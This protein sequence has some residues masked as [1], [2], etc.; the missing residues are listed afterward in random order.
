[1]KKS[2]ETLIRHA[3]H[4]SAQLI[5]QSRV[6]F[7]ASRVLPAPAE[8][9]AFNLATPDAQL[10][11]LAPFVADTSQPLYITVLF[12]TPHAHP[13][14]LERWR[15]AYEQ[16]AKK[17][18]SADVS[19]EQLY[20]NAAVLMRVLYGFLC[21]LPCSSIVRALRRNRATDASLAFH[22]EK[23]ESKLL[24]EP[25]RQ[26]V[27]GRIGNSLGAFSITAL[28][29]ADITAEEAQVTGAGAVLRSQLIVTDY[30]PSSSACREV[31]DD[32]K[33][34]SPT[35]LSPL[36]QQLAHY[37]VAPTRRSSS[38]ISIGSP[39]ASPRSRLGSNSQFVVGTAGAAVV[40]AS[41]AFALPM[42]GVAA[43]PM[44]AI[45]TPRHS[46]SLP[47]QIA[48][49]PGSA[50]GSAGSSGGTSQRTPD[51]VPVAQARKVPIAITPT[52]SVSIVAPAAVPA[53]AP[54][55][56]LYAPTPAGSPLEPAIDDS[57][58]ATSPVWLPP[59]LAED[60]AFAPVD[61]SAAGAQS[62]READ[63]GAFILRCQNPPELSLFRERPFVLLDH[64]LSTVAEDVKV[65]PPNVF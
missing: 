5:L 26:Q 55:V 12:E 37:G 13:S 32:S 20:R 49:P 50:P 18:R 42:P 40:A 35:G 48:H 59:A 61:T 65:S 36:S 39:Y 46:E 34:P 21:V 44:R 7:E 19:P 47:I 53:D 8:R 3:V 43:S 51:A 33:S 10:P 17:D 4:T 62:K 28:Y 63:I 30:S 57:Y 60:V 6:A 24:Y 2:T 54:L 1:M 14:V 38:P 52:S 31:P 9:P 27:I 45:S 22:L 11:E 29:R 15:I 23:E 64:L 16:H 56:S 58:D 25:F 41:P